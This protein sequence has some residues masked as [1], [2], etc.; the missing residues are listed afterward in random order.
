MNT[1]YLVTA[2]RIRQELKDLERVVHRAE[3]AIAAVQR[4]PEDED[5]YLDAAALS[6]HDFYA[7][8]ERV[9]QHIAAHVDRS[10]PTGP[11]WHRNLLRQM[12]IPVPHVRPRVL[13]PETANRLDEYLRFRHVVRNIYA[14]EFEPERIRRLVERLRPT[15]EQVRADLLAFAEFLEQASWDTEGASHTK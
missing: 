14:F 6:M 3:R 4:H 10:V 11:E 9:F 2:G 8:L 15:F 5:L 1:H 7:G 12:S 13:A